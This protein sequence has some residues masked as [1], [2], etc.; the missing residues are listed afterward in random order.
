MAVTFLLGNMNVFGG[1]SLFLARQQHRLGPGERVC[2]AE[3]PIYTASL[4]ELGLI[5]FFITLSSS[6]VEA[7]AA[8][9]YRR[10]AARPD[11]T[12]AKAQ[13]GQPH[14]LTLADAGEV[15]RLVVWLFWILLTTLDLGFAQPVA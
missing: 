8:A 1:F 7:V 12:E 10:R 15:L 2:R 6:P 13:A 4:I 11:G 14:R 9:A 3:S 5:L